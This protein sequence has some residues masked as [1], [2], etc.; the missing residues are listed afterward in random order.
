MRAYLGLPVKQVRTL[1]V[2]VKGARTFGARDFLSL[3]CFLLQVVVP[4]NKAI[5]PVDV[6]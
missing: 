3:L 6:V 2:I 4:T 5:L 1:S